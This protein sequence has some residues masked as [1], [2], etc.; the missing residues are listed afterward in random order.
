[1]QCT[2]ADGRNGVRNNAIGDEGQHVRLN[3]KGTFV[4]VSGTLYLDDGRYLPFILTVHNI[5]KYS[6]EIAAQDR[7]P[8]G[9]RALY[10]KK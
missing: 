9:K 3:T 7:H 4:S 8:D 6:A 5:S 10:R 1:M 2:P